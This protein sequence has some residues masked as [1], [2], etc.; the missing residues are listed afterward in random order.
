MPELPIVTIV[1][2]SY[3]Q[4]RFLEQTILSVLNQDYP[5]IE[6]LIIDGGSTDGS[7]EIIRRYGDRLAYWVSEP[8]QGQSHAINKGFQR[9]NGEILAWLNSDDLYCPGA[10]RAA[11]EF[12]GGHPEVAL[13]YGRAD[14]IDADGAV[15]CESPWMD[16]DVTTCLTRQRYP[17]PQPAAFFR[18]DTMQRVGLLDERLHYCLDWDYWIR[19]A[20]AG[21]TVSKIPQTLA[22]CRLHRDSKTVSELLKPNEE[23]VAW[24]DRFFAQPL[25]RRIA[26]L[27]RQS[28]SRA[29]VSL[30]RQ[31]LYAGQYARA[32]QMV[33]K[34]V[35]QY[36]QILLRDRAF[37][38]LTLSTLPRP[39]VKLAM[40]LKRLWFASP[41]ALEVRR[42][43]PE[44]A[45]MGSR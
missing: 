10:V 22:R 1:T 7:V 5:N 40:R 8:D 16:F 45:K 2:P 18:R 38:I 32:R 35:M 20:M 44:V 29:L 6:Y 27:E 30:G 28:R 15:V 34:G 21:L 26:E 31:H 19:I 37:L 4:A 12:L 41:P 11:V 36:P 13:A 39:A 14:L 23:M 17:I 3:N 33:L 25:P 43:A 9:A 24:I 42:G